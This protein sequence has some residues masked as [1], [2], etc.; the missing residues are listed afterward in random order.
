M[1]TFK[2]I[3]CGFEIR[4]IMPEHVKDQ[5]KP[6]EWMW[7]GGTVE[8]IHMPYGSVLDM[9]TYIIG[10]CDTCIE[11]KVEEGIIKDVSEL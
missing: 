1:E 6:E 10:I 2:C 11:K 7:N 4:P 9:N 8:R 3:C 5:D